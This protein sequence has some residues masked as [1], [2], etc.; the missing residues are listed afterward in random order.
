LTFAYAMLLGFMAI[1]ALLGLI[2]AGVRAPSQFVQYLHRGATLDWLIT[3]VL[4]FLISAFGGLAISVSQRGSI[5]EPEID[6]ASIRTLMLI[7][8]AVFVSPV[9][10]EI[11]FKPGLIDG[12]SRYVGPTAA[13]ILSVSLF[14]AFHQFSPFSVLLAIASSALYI[15]HRNLWQVWFVHIFSNATSFFWA[16][17]FQSQDVSLGPWENRIYAA[18][19]IFILALSGFVMTGRPAAL[20]NSEAKRRN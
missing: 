17:A 12:V 11:I 5:V 16:D 15:R 14:S 3:I 7:M 4:S 20:A 9:L 13:T 8:S 19:S 6:A 2:L 18:L 1:M 10:E